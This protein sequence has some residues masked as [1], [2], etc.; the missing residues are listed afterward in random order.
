MAAT[1]STSRST[2]STSPWPASSSSA[3]PPGTPTDDPN[4]HGSA[5]DRVGA[6][7]DGFLNGT[8]R[9]AEYEEIFLSGE[10]TAIPSCSPHE[11]DFQSG[12]NAP[13]DPNEQGNIFDLTFGSLETFWTAAMP[14]FGEEWDPLFLD[15]QVVAFSTDEPDS[16]PECPG[17][18]DLDVED[19]AGQAFTCFGDPDDPTDDFI[20]FD[21]EL[22]AG[23]YDEIGDFAVSGIISQQ[24]AF[25]AQVHARQPRRHDKAVVPPG[26][27]LQR[28]L[29][30]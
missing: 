11:E 27:L 28:R 24:Y 7:Q 3:T 21:I 20:A 6:F 9:C 29:G 22:A 5:F 23:L 4:A 18:D 15:D 8:D 25:V 12:G 10:S 16:L 2:T 26:R 13:F 30:R 1:C 19:V 14:Q 17:V